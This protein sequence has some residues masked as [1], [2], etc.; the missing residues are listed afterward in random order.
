MHRLSQ[1]VYAALTFAWHYKSDP[2]DAFCSA[3]GYLALKRLGLADCCDDIDAQKVIRGGSLD[4]CPL[5]QDATTSAQGRGFAE[6]LQSACM[7]CMP[8]PLKQ[9]TH[10]PTIM[11]GQTIPNLWGYVCSS[12]PA[13]SCRSMCKLVVNL[14]GACACVRNR[15]QLLN[16]QHSSSNTQQ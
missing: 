5:L 8:Q 10:M 13:R 12:A 15:P 14:V 2:H 1:E 3:G 9:N 16:L 11:A 4:P 7:T 6:R